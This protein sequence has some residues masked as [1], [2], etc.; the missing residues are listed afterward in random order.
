[1]PAYLLEVFVVVL[2]LV[3]LMVEAFGPREHKS[4]LGFLGA[5]GHAFILILLYVYH[6]TSYDK[7]NENY[8][9]IYRL[10]ELPEAMV[11]FRPEGFAQVA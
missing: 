11:R 1:M 9:R 6:E 4:A 10:D 2:G 7:F 5:G 3:L 8:D